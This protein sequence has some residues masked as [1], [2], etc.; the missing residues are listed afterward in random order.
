LIIYDWCFLI[1]LYNIY[2]FCWLFNNV[3]LFRLTFRWHWL[4]GLC[5][6]LIFL[7]IRL[8]KKLLN[9]ILYWLLRFI[10]Y[11]LIRFILH[12]FFSFNLT[13]SRLCM[14]YVYRF[15]DW[16]LLLFNRLFSNNFYW[17]NN[18]LFLWLFQV[19]WQLVESKRYWVLR[20]KLN[21]F[22]KSVAASIDLT[23]LGHTNGCALKCLYH[24]NISLVLLF[25]NR[26]LRLCGLNNQRDRIA[27]FLAVVALA[28]DEVSVLGLSKSNYS[29]V[30]E[31]CNNTVFAKVYLFEFEVIFNWDCVLELFIINCKYSLLSVDFISLF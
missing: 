14:I 30:G 11:R 6:D 2:N 21:V 24:Q 19:N 18:F 16:L 8:F 17:L 22:G 13:I 3:N 10:L 29:T 4:I 27:F 20:R 1:I 28:V 31:Q 12:R 26:L 7:L 25:F 23:C 9:I 15:F 5:R